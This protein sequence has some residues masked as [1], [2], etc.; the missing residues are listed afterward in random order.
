M[1]RG[2]SLNRLTNSNIRKKL[3]AVILLIAFCFIALIGRLFY[4]Q[5][6]VAEDIAVRGSGQWQRG[7]PMMARRG[8]IVD[9]NGI[10]ISSTNIR[11][12][13]Y[14]RPN[15]LKDK[16]T[17]ADVV[18]E[19]LDMNREKVLDK[20]SKKG[21]SEITVAKKID[22]TKMLQISSRNFSGVYFAEE[23]LRYYPYGDY[24]TQIL[25]F[26]NVDGYG[27]SGVEQYYDKYLRGTDGKVFTETDIVGKELEDSVASYLP[28]IDGMTVGLTI[29]YYIQSF[30]EKAVKDAMVS[31]RAKSASCIVMNP[32][33]GAISA[34]AQAP[35]FDLNNV[36]RDDAASLMS[37]MKN[38]MISNVYEPGSTFK[39][40]T[41]AIGI[42]EGVANNNSRYYCNGA[43]IVDGQRIKC[44][45]SRGHG[46]QTF[47][48]GVNNSCNCVF[49]DTALSVGKDT[50]YSYLNDFGATT[51]T[52]VDML[53]ESAGITLNVN[54]VKNVDLARIGFGQA[55]AVTP[56]A[57]ATS[58]SSVLN[59]GLSVTPYVMNNISDSRYGTVVKG[60]ASAQKRVVSQATSDKLVEYLYG[61]V[62]VG[63][64]K[65]A[66]NPGY[67]TGGKTGT[68]Q[69][70]EN[71]A[72]AQGKYVSSFLGFTKA[73][74]EDYLC[75]MIVDE[76]QGYVYYGSLVA[77]PYVGDIFKNIYAYKNIAPNYTEAEKKI[78]GRTF[79]MPNLIG[80][81]ITEATLL[82]RKL[83]IP[84][85]YDGEGGIVNYQLPS[86]NAECNYNT[87]VFMRT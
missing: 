2:G 43:R 25:G 33:T 8:D 31:Y 67:R 72:I 57:L 21:V 71:G 70:Y 56:I 49:M 9:R 51:K 15:A 83:G 34:M 79:T 23:S 38:S 4:L 69:K 28:P 81:S 45:Q 11:Y 17:V 39:I 80:M 37:M 48:Q 5:I 59:G 32:R 75:L 78:L 58:V 52:G 40:L 35:S 7:L 63:S 60:G 3:L 77:A 29:D 26:T 73:G 62:E 61:V 68:A 13:L 66:Y 54:N 82:M 14:V 12:R 10:V 24:L 84:Y 65:R 1:S 76:P 18:S 22:K 85:E 87:V 47:A 46:S 42:E 27:Q 20:I 53:G 30:A 44:W 16:G 50:F 6:A 64:G 36:P 74:N 41:S 86:P 55:I 19:V